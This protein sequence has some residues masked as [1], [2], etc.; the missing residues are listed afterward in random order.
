MSFLV[1]LTASFPCIGKNEAKGKSNLR[2][3]ADDKADDPSG[4]FDYSKLDTMGHPRL[5][6]TDADFTNLRTKVTNDRFS[7]KTL[8]KMHKMVM[9]LA[10]TYVNSTETI[11]YTFDAAGKRILGQSRLALSRIFACSYA[12][13][14]T[15]SAKYLN[16]AESDMQTVCDFQ[17]WNASRHFL[18]AAEMSLAVA[19]GYDWLYYD[20]SYETRL[21]AHRAMVD[22]ALGQAPGH[23]WDGNWNQVC[24]GGL[25]ADAL[26]LYEKDKVI[27]A[28]TIET[29]LKANAVAMED[30]YSPDG[31]Y[32]QGYMY[33]GYGTTYEVIML[34]MLQKIFGST[35]GL[36]DTEGFK[37]TGEYI[38]FMAGTTGKCFPYSDCSVGEYAKYAMWWFAAQ[39]NDP[40]MLVN[41]MRLYN[42]DKY[43]DAEE[44]RLLPMIPCIAM[45]I[46]NL[47]D[48][49][50]NPPKSHI[51]SGN[52]ETPV[53]LVHT[54]W[55]FSDTD[56]YL[57]IKGGKAAS[58]HGHMDAGSFV[59]DAYGVRWSEDLGMQSYA[60]LENAL[61]KAGGS[62]WDKKQNSMRWQVYRLNNLAH[63][64]LTVN[65]SDHRIDGKATIEKV[66]DEDGELGAKLDMTPVLSDQLAS[67]ERTVKLVDETDLFVIDRLTALRD[68]DANV[69]WR[70]M[71]GT[72]VTVEDGDIKLTSYSSDKTMYLTATSSDPSLS[73]TYT[74]WAAK[75][76]KSWDISN[77]GK[78]VAGYTVTIPA[79]T[80]V[81]LTTKLSITRQ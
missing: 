19:I 4:T 26:A 44:V 37:K 80:E 13:R 32:S 27:C 5:I 77:S 31:N 54:D 14:M 49:T 57:G 23:T 55:T 48:I 59:Y 63:S 34:T 60:A 36:A 40:S 20:L 18:D 28:K 62:L 53:V 30:A 3:E 65:D 25:V 9:D 2:D 76:S 64:T 41:E 21:K 67:A 72:T 12:Y 1:L 7:N 17:D 52:G 46:D 8:Y 38:L 39:E 75:G 69:Q 58:G 68:K 61:S 47:D 45:N 11:S 70:M 24:Y 33:W 66:I 74:S 10:D 51:W 81:T 29:A 78:T 73:I 15:G 71:T 16:K 50:S 56:K 43:T 22:Y 42:D 35:N 6:M 79:G